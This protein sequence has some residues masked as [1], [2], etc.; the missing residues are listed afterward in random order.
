MAIRTKLIFWLEIKTKPITELLKLIPNQGRLLDLGCGL[1]LISYIVSKKYPNLKIT[2][3]DPSKNRVKIAK[4]TYPN[5]KFEVGKI[6]N[7][8]ENFDTILLIDV[9]YLLSKK[10]LIKTLKLCY[11]KGGVLIIKTMN[12]SRFIR[13]S[14]LILSSVILTCLVLIINTFFRKSKG[15]TKREFKKIILKYYSQ[16]ELKKILEN[17]GWKVKIY[18]TPRSIYPSIIYFCDKNV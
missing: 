9:I 6:K 8:K 13:Y 10:E 3:I 2:G 1:G 7:I 12:K 16:K 4:K 14:F 5:I 17:I 11:E 15:I 18:D